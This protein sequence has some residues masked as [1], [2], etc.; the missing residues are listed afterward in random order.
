LREF[1]QYWFV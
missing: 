1:E